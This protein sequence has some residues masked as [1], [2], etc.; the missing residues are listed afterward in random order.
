MTVLT[1][2]PVM[3]ETT[4]TERMQSRETLFPNPS[5]I[6]RGAMS[7]FSSAANSMSV[8]GFPFNSSLPCLTLYV[9]VR[10]LLT[11]AEYGQR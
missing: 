2:T 7:C 3:E 6:K 1:L 8:L 9:N 5:S 10:H 4:W 11:T